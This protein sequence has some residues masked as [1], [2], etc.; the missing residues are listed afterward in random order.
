MKIYGRHIIRFVKF[1]WEKKESVWLGFIVT[2]AG[3]RGQC[4]P[5]TPLCGLISCRQHCASSSFT[6]I[7]P[8]LS[9]TSRGRGGDTGT[10][11]PRRE[12]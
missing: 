12:Y 1:E 7:F 8:H 6:L 2:G 10:T 4:W 11:K 3:R 5:L 9:F